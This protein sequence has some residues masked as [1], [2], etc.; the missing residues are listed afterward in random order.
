MRK[1]QGREVGARR[2]RW[3]AFVVMVAVLFYLEQWFGDMA[4]GAGVGLCCFAGLVGLTL[5]M[6]RP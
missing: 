5:G 3:A 1:P 2:L 6:E 4:M